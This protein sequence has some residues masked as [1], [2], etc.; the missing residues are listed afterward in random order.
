MHGEIG[1]EKTGSMEIYQGNDVHRPPVPDLCGRG[2]VLLF[3][4]L[5]EI[6][7]ARQ[8]VNLSIKGSGNTRLR[9]HIATRSIE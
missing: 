1:M 7:Q 4:A 2:K 5:T 8:R 6:E 3:P 9:R